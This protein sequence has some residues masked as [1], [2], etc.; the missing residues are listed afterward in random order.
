MIGEERKL[1]GVKIKI[2]LSK[3]NLFL[4]ALDFPE[5]NEFDFLITNVPPPFLEKGREWL[6]LI[7]I[8]NVHGP[9][10]F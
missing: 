1:A 9:F 4:Y 5:L 6:L 2:S 8:P 10:F 3:F 7:M